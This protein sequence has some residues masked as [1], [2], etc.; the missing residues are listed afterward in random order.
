[1]KS[2]AE[3]A[4]EFQTEKKKL[5]KQLEREKK[6]LP[7]ELDT[8]QA[9]L[10]IAT[11][12]KFPGETIQKISRGIEELKKRIGQKEEVPDKS[13]LS[14][15]IGENALKKGSCTVILGPRRTWK[16]QL[17]LD[18][19]R[20]GS[21]IGKAGLLLSFLDNQGTIVDQRHHLCETYCLQKTKNQFGQETPE[22]LKSKKFEACYQNF[23]LFHFRPGCLAPGE[24]F[25]HLDD[26][27][28]YAYDIYNPIDRFVFWD[29]TQLE[30]RFPLLA[31]DRMFLPGLIDFLKYSKYHKNDVIERNII[32]VFM[33]AP[34]QHLAQTAS[35][36][37]DN[38]IFTWSDTY[39]GLDGFVFYIDRIEGAPGG[40]RLH[41]LEGQKKKKVKKRKPPKMNIEE[42]LYSDIDETD[43]P[44]AESMIEEIRNLQGLP[45]KKKDDEG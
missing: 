16:T 28:E 43:L 1:M 6:K 7:E 24:F 8:K 44:Y 5:E 13:I 14:Y 12:E 19:L 21:R 23:Y 38:V 35:A 2:L 11:Q 32:S 25:H 3:L 29:L 27:I 30:S 39:N 31:N 41:F 34:N 45:A 26:R 9:E 10:D 40:K 15:I 36:M 17:T 33:G 18:F 37:A 20:A 4:R 42:F 22:C